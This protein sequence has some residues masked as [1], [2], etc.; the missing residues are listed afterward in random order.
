MCFHSLVDKNRLDRSKNKSFF[1][2]L[3]SLFSVSFD[4]HKKEYK[5]TQRDYGIDEVGSN[6]SII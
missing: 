4:T 1:A 3:N 5:T 6:Y 2:T